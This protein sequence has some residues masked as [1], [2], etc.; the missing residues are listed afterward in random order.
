MKYISVYTK[1][2]RKSIRKLGK[3][4]V[5]DLRATEKVM[6]KLIDGQKLESKYQDHFLGGEYEGYKECHIKNDLLLIYEIDKEKLLITFINIGS[7]QELFG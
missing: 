2:F 4:G 5:F 6:Q 1:K 7:H 3:S